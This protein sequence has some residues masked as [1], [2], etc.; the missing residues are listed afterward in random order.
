MKYVV[1]TGTASGM[2]KATAEY[3]SKKGYY[4]FGLDIKKSEELSENVEQIVCDVTSIESVKSAYVMVNSKTQKLDAII[5]FAGI[6]M[7]NSLVEI[8]EED[9]MKIFNVNVFGAYRVNKTFLPLILENKGKIIITTSEVAENKILPFNGIYGIT[10]KALDAYGEGLTHELG[11]LGVKVVRLRPGA[12]KTDILNHSSDSMNKM[13]D[14]TILYKDISR[15]F[16]K[17]V[18][19]EQGANISPE[20]IAELVYRILTRKKT[21][22]VYRKNI[23][24]KL[25][26]LN[27]L[28]T[29]SQLA[30]Y[31][32]ILK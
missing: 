25:K 3:L 10:K 11:L 23:S 21:K 30:I 9:F 19:S 26:L 20:K 1:I 16:K 2:G 14:N 15:K 28:S 27:M 29:K 7:M 32:K 5:N 6:I 18:D 4:V 31:K 17:I 8:S 12:V 13:L 24:K 22:L